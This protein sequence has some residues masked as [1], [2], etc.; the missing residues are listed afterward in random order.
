MQA[1]ALFVHDTNSKLLRINEPDPTDPAPRLFLARTRTQNLWRT[2]YDLPLDLAV[3][4]ERLAAHEPVSNDLFEA[5]RY[6]A[7]YAELLKQQAPLI[8]TD[9]GPA[10]Y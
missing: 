10:Y 6:A 8:T 7:E 4:L 9:S 5:P 3:E 2:R 1:E